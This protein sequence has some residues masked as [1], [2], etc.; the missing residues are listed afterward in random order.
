MWPK[1]FPFLKYKLFFISPLKN[2]YPSPFFL[3][4][5]NVKCIHFISFWTWI[6]FLVSH[7]VTPTWKTKPSLYSYSQPFQTLEVTID[8]VWKDFNIK[9]TH[10]QRYFSKKMLR[11]EYK[12]ER[13]GCFY[14]FS[15]FFSLSLSS[16]WFFVFWNTDF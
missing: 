4:C 3:A 13:Q 6:F 10:P 9:H 15:H 5:K 16:L 1:T 7:S 8:K 12:K 11:R 2:W 14:F